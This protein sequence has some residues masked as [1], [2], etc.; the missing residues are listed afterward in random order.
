MVSYQPYTVN[1]INIPTIGGGGQSLQGLISQYDALVSSDAFKNVGS[2]SEQYAKTNQA[3]QLKQK[4]DE[5]SAQQEA[6]RGRQEFKTSLNDLM[7]RA[8]PFAGQRA[9]YQ[10]KLADLMKN[11]AQAVASNPFFAASAEAGQEAAKR[12]L[13]QMGIGTSGN[14]A[15]ELQ[16]AAQ[17][18][19][20]G[21]YFR[22]AD[23]LGGF[24]GAGSDP[25]AAA[26]AGIGALKLREDQRQF[27]QGVNT[28]NMI[29]A[30]GSAAQKS[31]FNNLSAN[32]GL[33]SYWGG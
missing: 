17:S 30:W 21:D 13:A 27:D 9:D 24:A 10:T 3:Q 1:P 4:I 33:S 31:Q 26:S 7:S 15:L 18:N 2:I 28:R 14:A 29:P 8:D 25:S 12:R 32:R 11:P 16:K 6:A 20:S 23:L 22:M 19:M 5:M